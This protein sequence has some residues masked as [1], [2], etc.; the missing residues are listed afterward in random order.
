MEIFGKSAVSFSSIVGDESVHKIIKP[1]IHGKHGIFDLLDQFM[2]EGQYG[3]DLKLIL[4]MLFVKGEHDWFE[5][6][7]KPKLGR[8][9]IKEKSIRYDVPVTQETFFRLSPPEQKEFFL[10]QIADAIAATKARLEKKGMQID[11]KAM[12]VDFEQLQEAYR[13]RPLPPAPAKA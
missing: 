11:F 9:S 1:Y 13:K 8:Y 7:D 12:Q 10:Q 6:P 2:P 5:M 4:I 3:D